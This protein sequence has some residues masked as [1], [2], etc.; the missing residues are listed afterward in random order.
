[1]I[2][3]P[4]IIVNQLPDQLSQ[5]EGV[6]EVC[7]DGENGYSTTGGEESDVFTWFLSPEEAGS[8]TSD[9]LTATIVWSSQ[10]EGMAY[11]SVQAENSCGV[12]PLSDTLEINVFG[13]PTPE[14]AGAALVCIDEEDSYS[15]TEND[16]N[17]YEWEVIGGTISSGEGTNEIV[18]HWGND[19]G[20]GFVIVNESVIDGCST[21]DAFSVTIDDC[22]GIGKNT[23]SN[24]LKIYPNPAQSI[25]NLDFN[26]DKGQQIEIKI[27]NSMGVLVMQKLEISTGDKQTS[28][29]NIESL[30]RGVYFV[31][32]NPSGK[33]VWAGKFTKN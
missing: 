7:N 16:G 26:A 3:E 24:D 4:A 21:I 17:S 15:T 20:Q 1:M 27:Y 11:L 18:V 8:V 9:G 33:A 6:T 13:V 10:F 25:L 30:P 28:S 31:S 32:I 22:L 5:P 12:G 29:V 19:P 23:K 2:G 14:I